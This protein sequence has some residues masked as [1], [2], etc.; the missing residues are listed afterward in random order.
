MQGPAPARPRWRRLVPRLSVRMLLVLVLVIG[1]GLGWVVHSARVQREAVEAIRRAGGSVQYDW[2]VEAE[3]AALKN[4][5]GGMGGGFLVL[6]DAEP[7]W[8]RWLVDRLGVDFFG[9]VVEV[10]V[11]GGGS[12]A[13]LA[14]IGRLDRLDHL[15]FLDS[16]VSP[17]GL[18]RL[19]TLSRLKWLDLGETNV[20]DAGLAHLRGLTALEGLGLDQTRIGDAGLAHL[21]EMSNLRHL[22]LSTTDVGDPGLV[23][24]Q[25]LTNLETLYLGDTRVTI[26]ETE[27]LA[28][29]HPCL[30]IRR[31]ND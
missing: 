6:P 13:L 24:L 25:G 29:S 2:Q 30:D 10:D 17:A 18:S 16:D 11:I 1:G 19:R 15:R 7:P 20:T 22:D 21:A 4:G 12:D 31:F 28:R 3:R 23:R 14:H 8:P 9:S 27:S 5:M 26:E